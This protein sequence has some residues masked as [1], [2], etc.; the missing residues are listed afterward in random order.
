MKNQNSQE[1]QKKN[2]KGLRDIASSKFISMQHLFNLS[3]ILNS[4]LANIDI[5]N[6]GFVFY[7]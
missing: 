6:H 7:I 3:L 5:E 2:L 1:M 4:Y